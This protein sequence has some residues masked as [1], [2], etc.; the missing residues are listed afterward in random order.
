MDEGAAWRFYH[1][2]PRRLLTPAFGRHQ[3]GEQ[4]RKTID[5]HISEKLRKALFKKLKG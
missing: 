3:P 5:L 2:A 1:P 4:G